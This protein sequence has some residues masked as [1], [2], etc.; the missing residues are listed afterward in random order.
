MDRPES[1]L[2]S[3]DELV[4][5]LWALGVEFVAGDGEAALVGLPTAATLMASLVQSEEA[6]LRLAF[7]PLLLVHPSFS[8]SAP[9]ALTRVAAERQPLF[10]LLYTA[11]R[12]LQEKYRERLAPLV[13]DRQPLPAL[14]DQEFGL[15]GPIPSRL[16]SLAEHHR[17]ITGQQLNWLGSYEH[18][19]RRMVERL[20]RFE[21][22]EGTR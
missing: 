13:Q 11:A 1:R 16:E 9:D 5:A 18:A 20:E 22:P 19:A 7:I 8:A 3:A 21:M 2:L 10:K 4:A 17:H 12:L 14:Y 6:R 15:S